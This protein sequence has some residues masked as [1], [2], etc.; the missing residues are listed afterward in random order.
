MNPMSGE[1]GRRHEGPARDRPALPAGQ[2]AFEAYW[3]VSRHWPTYSA[4]ALVLALAAWL[5]QF[6]VMLIVLGL[7]A[8]ASPAA[9]SVVLQLAYMVTVVVVLVVGGTATFISSQRA[10]V[11]GATPRLGEALRLQRDDA[12]VLR[13][14]CVYWLVVHLVPTVVVNGGYV[15]EEL[16]ATFLPALPTAANF[17]IYW[18]WVLA[19]APLVVLS[20]PIVLFERAA[21]PLAEGRRRLH[22]N[23]GRL[24]VASALAFAP[25]VVV[26][27]VLV[28]ARDLVGDPAGDPLLFWLGNVL[29]LTVLQYASSFA[30]ILVMSALV[31][32]AYVRLSPRLELVYR[33]FD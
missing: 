7:A 11:L 18:A 10:S 12:R 6:L 16:N 24:F 1:E 20:L 8:T 15:A 30:T 2:L 23:T 5:A 27:V 4:Q 26:E 9:Q 25:V 3:L 13:A 14:V 32:A 17:V 22:G 33:V 19:T 21:D 28:L 29:A 31:A